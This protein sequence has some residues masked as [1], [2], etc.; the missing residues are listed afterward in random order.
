MYKKYTLSAK[1]G[2]AMYCKSYDYQSFSM[3]GTGL[4]MLFFKINQNDTE[5]F[6]NRLQKFCQE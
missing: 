1:T 3:P 4:V 5:Q 6:A 2:K